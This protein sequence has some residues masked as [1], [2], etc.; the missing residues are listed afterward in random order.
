MILPSRS[1][2]FRVSGGNVSRCVTHAVCA[3]HAK[4]TKTN[5]TSC[6]VHLNLLKFMVCLYRDTL[7]IHNFPSSL[8]RKS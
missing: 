4:A 2:S 7:S 8:R 5:L 6:I 1:N 3:T